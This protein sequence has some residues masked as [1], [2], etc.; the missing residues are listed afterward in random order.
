MMSEKFSR[1]ESSGE[2]YDRR[3]PSPES[4]MSPKE[5]ILSLKEDIKQAETQIKLLSKEFEAMAEDD[6]P[7]SR[8]QLE[9]AISKIDDLRTE[10]GIVR[11]K[12]LAIIDQMDKL[13]A[14]NLTAQLRKPEM[15][16]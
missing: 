11:D 12:I 7:A 13:D 5:Q 15:K 2:A 9:E 8:A 6:H 4:A 1:D 10:Q 16:N 3:D 14:E